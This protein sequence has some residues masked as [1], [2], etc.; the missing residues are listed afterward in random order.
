[1]AL[2]EPVTDH[3]HHWS[4]AHPRIGQTVHSHY[5]PEPR[6]ATDPIGTDGLADE[7]ER[8]GGLETIVLTNRH[9]LRAGAELAGRLGAR[10]LAPASGMHEFGA[11][12][13]VEPY[14]WGD[15]LAPGVTAHEVG[16]ICPDDGALHIAAGDGA[17]VLADSVIRWDGE[18]AFVPDFLMDEPEKV[19]AATVEA[20]ER[21]CDE[22]AFDTLLLAHGE[23]VASGGREA[24]REFAQNPRQADFSA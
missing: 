4:A 13:P 24:L 19:K 17:L 3:V 16:A 12:D 2:L 18:L 10:I 15:E 9:H 20:L 11:D 14:E 5:L 6:L 8:A 7:I 21:L 23:P 1:M 22:L